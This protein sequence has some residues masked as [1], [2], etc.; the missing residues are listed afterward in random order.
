MS[1]SAGN[2]LDAFER[3]LADES[4]ITSLFEEI[5]RGSQIFA[6]E[7]KMFEDALNSVYALNPIQSS[8]SLPHYRST[9]WRIKTR[10]DLA[11]VPYTSSTGYTVQ[12]ESV[13]LLEVYGTEARSSLVL[14]LQSALL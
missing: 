5:Q 12:Y 6:D 1:L 8:N 4:I 14:I 11:S 13:I 3:T 2:L 9:D 10:D 7:C